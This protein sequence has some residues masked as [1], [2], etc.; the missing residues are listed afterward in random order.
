MTGPGPT[1]AYITAGAGGMYCGSCLQDNA[2]AAALC[3][4]GVDVQL[5]PTYT[6]I[7]TDERDVSLDRVFLGGINVFLQQKSPLF[8]RIPRGLARLLDHPRLLR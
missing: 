3:R 8:R 7:R 1:I 4:M 5:I 2:L 6:P